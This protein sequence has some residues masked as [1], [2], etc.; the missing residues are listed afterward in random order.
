MA[1]AV[2]DIR[3][4]LTLGGARP[5]Q[6]QVQ[7][8]NPANSI[9]DIKLPFLCEAASIPPSTLGTI[10]VPY[11]G[12]TIK[13]AG[14]RTYPEWSTTVMND[15]DF[16][17][18]NAIENWSNMINTFE[19]NVRGFPTSAPSAYK[20]VGLVNQYGQTGVIIRTYRLQG[21]YPVSVTPIELNWGATDQIERFQ[22]VWN[23]DWWSVDPGVT[24][25]AGG[26]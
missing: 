8:T 6:F 17:I 22:V 14:D 12:R 23:Y 2:N 20:S 3:S 5:T 25:D 10:P 13:L 4:N 16:L 19:G 21:L 7:I 1:F 24:G 18:R 26:E 15:E 9:A 11:F